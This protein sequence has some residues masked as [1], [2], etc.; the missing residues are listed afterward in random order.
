M[1]FVDQEIQNPQYRKIVQDHLKSVKARDLS[2]QK[3]LQAYRN[4]IKWIYN[5]KVEEEQV[6]RLKSRSKLYDD[7][8]KERFGSIPNN[9]L[10]IRSSFY[11]WRVKR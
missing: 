4:L 1:K 10:H 5:K 11:I 7:S 3:N 2:D 6:L 8:L 9:C